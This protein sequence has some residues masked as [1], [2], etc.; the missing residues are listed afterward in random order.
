MKLVRAK[1]TNFK[2]IDDTGW[3]DIGEVTSMV[4]KNES[5]KTAFLGALKRL[6]PVDGMDKFDLKDYPR[7]G[8]VRYKRDHGTTPAIVIT[9]EL[10]LS[11]D[12]MGKIE[13]ALGK[14]AL[15]SSQVTVAKD[16]A[17]ELRWDVDVNEQ[18]IVRHL[19]ESANIPL[20]VQEHARK[21]QTIGEL[22]EALE[23]LDVK[24][25]AVQK[26]L[27]DVSKRFEGDDA[28]SQLICG[29]LN[30]FLPKFVYFDEYSAM[31]GRISIQDMVERVNKGE[32]MD[33]S[34]RTFLSLLALVG[35]NLQDMDNQTN[36]EYLKA[37]LESA[38]IGISDEI[39]EYWNQ[40]KQLR[41]EFDLSAA[42]PDD[43]PPLNKGTILHVRIWNNRHRVSVPFDERS[44]GFVWFFSFLSYF[45]KIEEEQDTDLVLLLDEP[46]LNLHAMAQ[47]DFL[48]FIDERLAPKHQVIYTTHSPF[49]INLKHLDR[50][51]TVQD[52]DDRG[53][54][55]SDDTLSN[56]QETVFPLQVAL[57][58]RLANT[59]FLAPH[60]LMVNDASDL[61]LLQ[62]I[63]EFVSSRGHQ[64]LDPRWVVIPVGGADNL[65]SFV[66]LLGE[67]YVS[68]AVLMDV[69]PKNKEK[70]EAIN[71]NSHIHRSNPIKWVE[72]TKVR[73]A[74]IEDILDPAF[75]LKLVNASYAGELSEPITMKAITDSEPRIAKRLEVYFEA[76]GL[77]N[78]GKFEAY[79]PAAYLLEH[80]AELRGQIDDAT[81]ERAAS[82]F[83]RINALLP[84]NAGSDTL[85]AFVRGAS[86]GSASQQATA[87]PA[88]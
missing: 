82:M 58:H 57:G 22:V 75:Y 51:R 70:M 52:V 48:R 71:K 69:T 36:Y 56:D 33:E 79:R 88:P 19:M 23:S 87:T 60:C 72:V 80:H 66:S 17:N 27:D 13:E 53:T 32:E 86:N 21:S 30:K 43:P 5:G 68:V 59:L 42:N 50:I 46:G 55:I 39:F 85:G 47:H 38:S 54:V 24:P 25:A 6:N 49:M 12:E 16:Y 10:E 44:K 15:K 62:I 63:G 45:S 41:V 65:P 81:I 3:V 74:D 64:R 4:G 7:K 20:E 8:Y 37:E 78:N 29:Y 1:V 28:A 26:L 9:T 35:A 31:R 67:N 14:G 77:G 61:I 40:N 84:A 83:E 2:S 73:T 76:E 11:G 18:A 34:D